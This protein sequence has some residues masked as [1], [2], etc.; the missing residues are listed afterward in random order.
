MCV[1]LLQMIAYFVRHRFLSKN[2]PAFVF[3]MPLG[4][5]FLDQQ[6]CP[7]LVSRFLKNVKGSVVVSG[8]SMA[9][10]SRAFSTIANAREA[11]SEDGKAPIFCILPL[12][13]PLLL[14]FGL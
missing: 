2:L 3:P 12:L 6:R 8:E 5:L 7:S 4:N 10:S 14:P 1:N 13:F 11:S 9:D